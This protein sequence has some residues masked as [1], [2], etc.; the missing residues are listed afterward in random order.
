MPGHELPGVAEDE[1]RRE[2]TQAL[3]REEF[4]G[5]RPGEGLP[6]G[7]FS[8][9]FLVLTTVHFAAKSV[10]Q[11][12]FID[13]LGAQNLPWVYLAVAVVSFPLLIGYSRL[14]ARFRV[15]R[16]ILAF[17]FLHIAA[18]VAFFLLFGLGRDWVAVLYYLWLG[19]AF[20]I[21]VS[22]FWTYAIQVFDPRQARRL[23]AVIGAGGLLGATLGG[24]LAVVVTRFAGT[25]ATLLAA[26]SF[27][28]LVPILV[29]L[30]ERSREGAFSGTGRPIGSRHEDARGGLRTLRGSRLL[31]LISLLMLATVTVGQLV[32]W[33]FYWYV[34]KN[35]DQLDQR[36]AVIGT[37]FILIGVV[38]F[39]FQLFF[40][41]RIHNTLGV[42]VGMRVLPGSVGAAQLAVVLAI[43]AG[44]GAIYPLVWVLLLTESSLRHSLDQ[45][46]RELLFLP[47]AEKLRVRAKAFIDVF[48]QRFAKGAAAILILPVTFAVMPASYVS[49]LTLVLAVGWLVLTTRVRK[50]YVIAYREG[51]KSG[52]LQ[53]D[54]T[55]DP[56]DVTTVTT[57]VQSLGSTDP[58]QVLHALDLLSASGEGR[59][60]NPLLL[61][62][63]S[64]EVRRRTLEILSE[65]G[66]ADAAPLVERALSD[67]DAGVRTGAIRTL[68]RLRGEKAAEVMLEHLADE[69]PR[70]RA[71]AMASLLGGPEAEGRQRAERALAELV[72]DDDPD[73]RA[74]AARALGHVGDPAGSEV[75]VQLLYDRDLRVVRASIDAVRQRAERDGVN[76]LYATILIALMGNRR[77]K[78]EAREALVAGG[79]AV[80]ES[81]ELFMKSPDEQIWVRRAVPKTIA[82]IGSQRAVDALVNN[83]DATDRI[84][85]SKIIEAL[86]YLRTRDEKIRVSR[87][88]VTRQLSA[89]A[90][91]Y[92]RLL[93]DLWAV[94][95]L[96]EARL[97]G[98][99]AVWRVDGRVPTLPQQLLA[100]R[101]VT[102]V[103]AIFGL[104][105]LIENPEDVRAAQRSL[106]SGQVHLR[107]RALEYLD[108]TLT[109]SLRRDVFAVI[110]DSPPEGKLLRARAIFGIEVQS[111]EE[112][113]ERLIRADPTVDPSATGIVLAALHSVW[114]EEITVLYPL[115]RELTEQ[116]EDPL[117]RE[118]AGWVTRRVRSGS[119]TR[120][121][122]ST[123][124]ENHMAP[125]AHIEM[126]VFLQGVDLFAHC[127]AEQVLRLAA[128]A[129]EQTYGKDE[130]VFRHDDPADA[131]Y[132]VVEGKV[133]LDAG[134]ERGAVVGPSGRFGVLDILSGRP[135]SGDATT[136]TDTRLL[137]IDAEDFYDLLSNNIEIVKALFRSVV[138]LREDLDETL[139]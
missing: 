107:A 68:A 27:L 132:C 89:E 46:T 29:V 87:R 130:V 103:A 138:A 17:T 7:L 139:L 120:G 108:N 39:L 116:A 20:A 37:A 28:L 126:M 73:S 79:E 45:A 55:I 32:Q 53:P 93:A 121:V 136:L 10:R 43:V 54:A 135:R 104:L 133:R 111:P 110:D 85:R 84:L 124:G 12:S 137:T 49:W 94:S 52:M 25:R 78:H 59:L 3:S 38:G 40:T 127:N 62:H 8:L 13:A 88:T 1:S 21:A 22:Q 5:I 100:Q 56:A 122:I 129:R 33:Q 66:R 34:Q 75:L 15:A 96:H 95:S 125:M 70:L 30:I 74:E 106:L 112:T 101:M 18:L 117:V 31:G 57:L 128:I 6:A 51:L 134:G 83:L 118:T 99:L 114:F 97:D 81:L 102:A 115:A 82:L 47:V 36:T 113:L 98:P 61:H 72:A 131:L 42:G 2:V 71:S 44:S 77:L 48:V 119:R 11:A 123:G 24:G 35:T 80:L 19:I 41:R 50:E 76:P 105:E 109:G 60:V 16:L 69:D 67:E 9:L 90:A 65:T 23:F 58:R 86:V 26:A 92:L 64:A 63:E 4:F 14:A 91:C